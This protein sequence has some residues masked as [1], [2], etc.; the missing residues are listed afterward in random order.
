[1]LTI[2]GVYHSRASRIYW[3][4]N[5][6]GLDFK[7]VPVIQARKV[8]D[9]LG[10]SAP[11][12]TRTPSFLAINPMGQVP[13]ID[14]DGFMVYE[15]LAI[16]LYLAKKHGGPLAPAS[17]AEDASMTQW[18]LWAATE[19][20]PNAL[21]ISQT[22][23]RGEADTDAGRAALASASE[24]LGRPFPVIERHLGKTGYLVGDRFTVA[25]LNAAEVIRYAQ[26]HAGLMDRFPNLKGWLARC[27]AR[28]A[29]KAMWKTREAE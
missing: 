1:M 23:E 28:P 25:D 12:N 7:S 29:F 15:S 16:T 11:L 5:E 26:G 21:R 2:Y 17:L 6:L 20:E 9:P 3:I 24:A 8:A 22:F 13:C 4:A 14:D 10:P 27:Q 19:V 18:S